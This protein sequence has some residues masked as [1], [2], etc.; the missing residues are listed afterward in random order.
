[1]NHL[2]AD[3]SGRT[4]NFAGGFEYTFGALGNNVALQATV[5]GL[6]ATVGGAVAVAGDFAF[7]K[8]ST[9]M[10][11]VGQGAS[12]S[13]G[14]GS[15]LVG[16]DHANFGMHIGT[17][18]SVIEARG[19][20]HA[21]LGSLV[22]MTADTV[23]LRWNSTNLDASNTTVHAGGLDYVYGA[24]LMASLKEVA[25]GGASLNVGGFV[26]ASGNIAVR[27]SSGV[28]VKLGDG[29]S[30]TVDELTFGASDMNVF[31]GAGAGTDDKL[32]LAMTDVD[33]ALAVLAQQGAPLHNW[34]ALTAAAGNAEFVGIDGFKLAASDLAVAFNRADVTSDA[35]VDFSATPVEVATGPS[36]HVSIDLDGTKGRLTQVAIGRA[37]LAISDYVYISGSMVLEMAATTEVDVKTGLPASYPATMPADLR[38]GLGLVKGISTDHSRID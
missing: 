23:A 27:R 3:L 17:G 15:F 7:E 21:Q 37:T 31:V 6:H 30:V 33:L 36:S 1:M 9:G 20:L 11:V 18:G 13:I 10:A 22:S 38:T 12:A 4:L 2:G 5:M 24:G 19:S 25:L 29:S 35:V 28:Q 16:V 8:D 32:G 14:A 26:Q 34:T